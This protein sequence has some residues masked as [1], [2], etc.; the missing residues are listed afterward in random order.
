M[1]AHSEDPFPLVQADVRTN[2][3]KLSQSLPT[4]SESQRSKRIQALSYDVQDLSEAVQVARQDRHRFNLS[5]QELASRERFVREMQSNIVTA[6]NFRTTRT[7]GHGKDE[8]LSQT[9][10]ANDAYIND[11][12]MQ[13]EQIMRHQD[14]QLDELAGAVQRIGNMGRDMHIELEEQGQL[15]DNLGEE[16]EDTSSRMK[17]VRQ[18]LDRF[19][20]ETGPRQFCT[21]VWLS[22][23]FLVLTVLVVVT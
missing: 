6:R 22:V 17:R 2:W 12:M 7:A 18:S 14:E 5:E 9:R 19:I 11:E 10:R 8:L 1:T 20:E 23:T 16:M 13:Q 21:I 3:A 15:L 4:L